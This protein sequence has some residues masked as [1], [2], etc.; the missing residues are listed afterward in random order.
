MK[1]IFTFLTALLLSASVFAQVPQKMTYQAVVRNAEN[2]L[3]VE[4]TVGIQISI[5]QESASGTVVYSETQSPTTNTNG[6]VS[7]VIGEGT[8]V[9]GDLESIDWGSDIYFIKTE[10]DPL[11]GD[12]YTIT[13]V[14]QLLSVPYAFYAQ[15]ADTVTGP[16]KELDPV[17]SESPSFGITKADTTNLRNLS[18]INTGDQSLSSVL[19]VENLANDQIKNL[20]DPTDDQDAA[21]K[22]YVDALVSQMNILH[23][24]IQL[25]AGVTVADL[26]AAGASPSDLLAAGASITELVD[27][28]ASVADLLNESGSVA[29]LIAGGATVA[30]LIAGGATV[31]DLVDAGVTLPELIAG[32]APVDELLAEGYTVS[33]LLTGGVTVADLVAADAPILD[34]ILAGVSLSDLVTAG[35]TAQLVD[36]GVSTTSLIAAGASASDLIDAGITVAELITAGVSVSDL[37]AAEVTVSELIAE[38][39]TASDFIGVNYQGGIIFYVDE[40]D[41]T[42]LICSINDL[43]TDIEWG[44][45]MT[46]TGATGTAIGTGQTNTTAIISDQ[47]IG[48]YAAKL[49]DSYNPMSYNDWFLPSI[50][51]LLEMESNKTA[52]AITATGLGGS[53]LA[54]TTYWS[55][56]EI[57]ANNASTLTNGSQASSSKNAQAAVRAVRAF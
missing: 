29:D 11:G 52:I 27:A 8:V 49:C 28:G 12:S 44:L 24:T 25:N 45:T 15:A 20:T 22:A 33:Q 50:D 39:K 41:G 19:E 56:S 37:L 16:I 36:A 21:T 46:A 34:L 47:G 4:G 40:T 10:I 17:F 9:S 51:E 5:L 35:A 55:S 1:R 57:D 31:A 6:L 7:I 43:D 38:G 13:G 3:I 54:Q 14:S 30:D 42:G 23:L 18:G 26:V 2:T 32:N 48:S 53:G